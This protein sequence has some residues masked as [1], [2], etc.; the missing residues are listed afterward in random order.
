[1]PTH[2]TPDHTPV[3]RPSLLR[4]TAEIALT[5]IKRFIEPR[6]AADFSLRRVAAPV[7]LP[8]SAG[9]NGPGPAATFTLAGSNS[10]M[11]IV[12]G[13]DHWLRRQ[14]DRYDIA[15]GFGVFTVMNALRPDIAESLTTSP[16]IAAWSWQQ[17]L[18]NKTEANARLLKNMAARLYEVFRDTEKM[19]LAKFPHMT[20]TLPDTLV[21]VTASEVIAAIP[22]HN[23]AR[24]EH[25]Y[26]KRRST[27]SAY[28]IVDDPPLA[29]P[30]R[31]ARMLV[32]NQQAN[33]PLE[34]AEFTFYPPAA[35]APLP[36]AGANIWRDRLAMQILHQQ[37]ILRPL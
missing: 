32:W 18:D 1:M 27:Q 25:D 19:I 24:S 23:Q 13:L 28:L 7:Y 14:L 11:E 3:F 20:S 6:L 12:T 17:T 4:E 31:H 33:A 10:P 16:H 26:V 36:S 35:D 34:L 29:T 15:P 5:E 37:S 9:L 22:A 21:T 2:N 8:A 30:P